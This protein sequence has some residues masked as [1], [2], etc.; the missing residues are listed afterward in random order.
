ML[1][2]AM[3]GKWC[4]RCFVPKRM[5]SD[6]VGLRHRPFRQNQEWSDARQDSSLEIFELGSDLEREIYS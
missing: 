6:L 5:A 4:R 1:M 3:E 2:F